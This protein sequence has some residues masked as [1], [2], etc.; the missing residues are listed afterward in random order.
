MP[1]LILRWN[2]HFIP[3]DQASDGTSTESVSFAYE[4]LGIDYVYNP[5]PCVP[6]TANCPPTTSLTLSGD[7]FFTTDCQ[8]DAV[9]GTLDFSDSQI[10]P[11]RNLRPSSSWLPVFWVWCSWSLEGQ[12]PR[13]RHGKPNHSPRPSLLKPYANSP[14]D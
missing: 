9:C 13:P 1:V 2:W 5:S 11:Y 10:T 12:R 3:S 8:T 6:G 7:Q 14:K 4:I